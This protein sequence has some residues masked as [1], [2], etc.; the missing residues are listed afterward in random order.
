MATNG[1]GK[2]LFGVLNKF[3]GGMRVCLNLMTTL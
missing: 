1:I 3:Y 2:F